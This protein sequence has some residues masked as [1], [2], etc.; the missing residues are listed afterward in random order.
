MQTK[1]P[2]ANPF[3]CAVAGREVIVSGLR[4]ALYGGTPAVP[5]SIANAH[6]ACN[7]TP[8]C[9]RTFKGPGCPYFGQN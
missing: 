3:L 4:V 6:T 1:Q 8:G 2:F 9:G 5:V 7:G